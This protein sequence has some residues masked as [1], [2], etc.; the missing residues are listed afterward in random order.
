MVH[1]LKKIYLKNE[2]GITGTINVS[3]DEIKIDKTK[4]QN[5]TISY[6]K[7]VHDILLQG[8]TIRIL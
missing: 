4:P 1:I 2:L 6:S 8:I 3:S 5:L 7:S